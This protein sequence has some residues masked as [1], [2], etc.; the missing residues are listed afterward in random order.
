[1]FIISPVEV[2]EKIVLKPLQHDITIA[3]NTPTGVLKTTMLNFAV[4]VSHAFNLQ[5]IKH[6]RF[7]LNSS[8]IFAYHNCKSIKK[9]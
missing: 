2:R 5:V 7:R 9:F 8:V 3:D 6:K 4:K 1:M